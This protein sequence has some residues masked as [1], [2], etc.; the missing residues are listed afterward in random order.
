LKQIGD[1]NTCSH[2]ILRHLFDLFRNLLKPSNP[3]YHTPEYS[4]LLRHLEERIQNVQPSLGM[5]NTPGSTDAMESYAVNVELYKLAALIYLERVSNNFSGQS[6]KIDRYVARAFEIL[7][8][9]T[10]CDLPFPLLVF[11]CEARTDDRRMAILDVIEETTA[12]SRS[13]SLGGVQRMVQAIWVQDD[14]QTENELDYV[15]KLDTVIT[16]NI[17]MPPFA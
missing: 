12:V 16:S 7:A 2:E 17:I 8:G 11:G 6:E 1:I 10:T 14:L 9:M 4:L 5:D 3:A 13:R 15:M